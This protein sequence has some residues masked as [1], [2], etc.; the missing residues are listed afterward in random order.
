MS[1]VQVYERAPVSFA[2]NLARRGHHIVYR[3]ESSNHCPGCGRSNWHIGRITAECG[4]CGTA[5]PLAETARQEGSLRSIAGTKATGSADQRRFDRM[6]AKGRK[7]MITDSK[8]GMASVTI[9]DVNQ[10]NGV[11]HVVDAVLL[12]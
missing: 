3:A 5:V 7:L 9:P 8:G 10:S 12:P 2:A 11:I 6:P 4:F 1:N